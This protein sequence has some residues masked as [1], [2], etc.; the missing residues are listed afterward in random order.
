MKF[1]KFG[2]NKIPSKIKIIRNAFKNPIANI[3]TISARILTSPIA[4]SY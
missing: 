3:P 4:I 2:L 1:N